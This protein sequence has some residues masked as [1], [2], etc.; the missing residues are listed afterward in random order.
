MTGI[1]NWAAKFPLWTVT[2]LF[3]TTLL[4]HWNATILWVSDN[5]YIRKS[6][7]TLGPV[8]DNHKINRIL[9]L[10]LC[11]LCQ[12]FMVPMHVHIFQISRTTTWSEVLNKNSKGKHTWIVFWNVYWVGYTVKTGKRQRLRLLWKESCFNTRKSNPLLPICLHK[13]KG[14]HTAHTEG[15]LKGETGSRQM[16]ICQ[17]VSP[18]LPETV[19]TLRV[20]P[21]PQYT[22]VFSSQ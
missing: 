13:F 3:C 21:S 9:L 4:A 14:K 15:W 5:V 10:S 16:W 2:Y 18:N 1:T 22:Q 19:I 20:L 17:E 12:W 11:L 6:H 8:L 7:L